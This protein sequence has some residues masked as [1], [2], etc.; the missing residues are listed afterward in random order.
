MFIR[1]CVRC[2]N[3]ISNIVSADSPNIIYYFNVA[4]IVLQKIRYHFYTIY[5]IHGLYRRVF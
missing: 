4:L 3:S 2:T 1:R 5:G